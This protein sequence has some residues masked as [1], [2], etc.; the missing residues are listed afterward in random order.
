MPLTKVS[1]SNQSEV[2]SGI[3]SLEQAHDRMHVKTHLKLDQLRW[4]ILNVLNTQKTTPDPAVVLENLSERLIALAD[5]AKRVEQEQ[6]ILSSLVFDSMKQREEKIKD[7]HG[8]TLAWAVKSP[9]T[10]FMDWLTTKSGIYWV[11]GK[12]SQPCFRYSTLIL[13]R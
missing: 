4:D 1:R 8:Q 10:G 7:A 2:L 5:A 6:R 11:K 3:R 12:V 13:T 9:E